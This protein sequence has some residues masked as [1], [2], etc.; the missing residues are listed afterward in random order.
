MNIL[1]IRKKRTSSYICTI[2]A[3]PIHTSIFWGFTAKTIYSNYCLLFKKTYLIGCVVLK[4]LQIINFVNTIKLITV[5]TMMIISIIIIIVII[6]PLISL[7]ID[8]NVVFFLIFARIDDDWL[9]KIRLTANNEWAAP[10]NRADFVLFVFLL[11]WFFSFDG[12]GRWTT[13]HTNRN[14]C[15]SFRVLRIYVCICERFCVCVCK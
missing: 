14:N 9:M 15:N 11:V 6:W 4:A 5:C 10:E 3:S 12:R 2:H 7:R 8:W 1:R 13:A